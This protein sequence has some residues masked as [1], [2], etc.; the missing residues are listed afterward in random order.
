MPA[1]LQLIVR[2][3]EYFTIKKF[4]KHNQSTSSVDNTTAPLTP[5]LDAHDVRFL[6]QVINEPEG[7][8]EPGNIIF[9]GS[10]PP[11]AL[12]A[13]DTP[14]ETTAKDVPKIAP[15]A[16]TGDGD[17]KMSLRDKWGYLEALGATTASRLGQAVK[18]KDKGKGKGKE[19]EKTGEAPADEVEVSTRIM[20][21][22]WSQ[23]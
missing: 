20:D 15:P 23:C 16:A 1:I 5:L 7:N 17:W 3:L 8:T 9:P 19:K 2:M 21:S 14:A 12:P 11:Q 18:G 13:V 6:A 10:Q 4:R 22:V